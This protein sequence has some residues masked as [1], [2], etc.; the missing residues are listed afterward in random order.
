MRGQA[1]AAVDAELRHE[2]S[3]VLDR[4][5]AGEIIAIL[6]GE[7]K[8]DVFGD[9]IIPLAAVEHNLDALR[10]LKP[11]FSEQQDEN[12][13]ARVMPVPPALSAP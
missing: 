10:H 8:N 2:R 5:V 7:I 12:M 13:S 1:H 6:S 3:R 9:R 4:H 11:Q